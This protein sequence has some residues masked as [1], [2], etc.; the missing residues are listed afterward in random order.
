MFVLVLIHLLVFLVPLPLLPPFLILTAVIVFQVLLFNKIDFWEENELKYS[1]INN[2]S[3]LSKHIK[4]FRFLAVSQNENSAGEVQV[5]GGD[6]LSSLEGKVGF[7][8]G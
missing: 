7:C 3:F 2:F 6:T 8:T 4:S 1:Q 5:V